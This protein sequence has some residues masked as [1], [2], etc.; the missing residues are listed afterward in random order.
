M[1]ITMKAC[2]KPTRRTQYTGEWIVGRPHGHGTYHS[3][4][5]NTTYVGNFD[6]GLRAGEGTLELHRQ[7]ITYRGSWSNDR[8]SG[9]GN[10]THTD[11]EGNIIQQYE[12]GWRNDMREGHGILR[13]YDGSIYDGLWKRGLRHGSGSF[14]SPCGSIRSYKGEWHQDQIHGRGIIH[15]HTGYIW[16]GLFDIGVPRGEG[17]MTSPNNSKLETHL[18]PYSLPQGRCA[19]WRE[20]ESGQLIKFAGQVGTDLLLRNP[21]KASVDVLALPPMFCLPFI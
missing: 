8:R 11:I 9:K 3:D 6:R 19:I 5:T 15:Y 20:D 1:A 12:G 7:G 17:I 18:S 13:D 14:T 4:I 10:E 16:A 21:D 2:I